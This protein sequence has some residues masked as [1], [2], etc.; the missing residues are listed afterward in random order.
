M[1]I[2]PTAPQPNQT[3]TVVLDGQQCRIDLAQKDPLGMFFTLYV[4]DALMVGGVPCQDR[5]PLVRGAYLGFTG[6]LEFRDAEGTAD[7]EYTGLNTRFFLCYLEDG[8]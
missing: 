3:F 7:P 6:N 4:N 5:N 1:L 2:V 8:E